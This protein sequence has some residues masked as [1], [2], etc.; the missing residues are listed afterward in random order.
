MILPLLL[1][2]I[3]ILLL[4]VVAASVRH[5]LSAR[6]LRRESQ[7]Q[8]KHASF[9]FSDIR[10]FPPSAPPHPPL[11][12]SLSDVINEEEQR[13]EQQSPS[14]L[15]STATPFQRRDSVGGSQL[16]L[17]S[18]RNSVVHSPVSA[19]SPSLPHPPPSP[20]LWTRPPAF[21]PQYTN[22]LPAAA[23]APSP[24]SR[25]SL[26]PLLSSAATSSSLK[27]SSSSAVSA[28][29]SISRKRGAS[30]HII[31][32]GDAI[33]LSQPDKKS[34]H[35]RAR[36]AEENDVEMADSGTRARAKRKEPRRHREDREEDEDGAVDRG[37]EADG[38]ATK[39][40][41]R[42]NVLASPA[43]AR[44]QT[45][46]ENELRTRKRAGKATDEAT[47]R[48]RTAAVD[49]EDRGQELEVMEEEAE[50]D[51]E[52]T[53]NGHH[54]AD[55][56]VVDVDGS[57]VAE[58]DHTTETGSAAPTRPP[59]T[60]SHLLP[61][62]PASPFLPSASTALLDPKTRR[63]SGRMPFKTRHSLPAPAA[64]GTSWV[65]EGEE[66]TEEEREREEKVN[67]MLKQGLN[68]KA[69]RHLEHDKTTADGNQQLQ[70]QQQEEQKVGAGPPQSING[71]PAATATAASDF[72][73]Q[74]QQSSSSMSL[75]TFSF[76][77]SS[78]ASQPATLSFTAGGTPPAFAF[79][80][81]GGGTSAA[82][83]QFLT[84]SMQPSNSSP[85]TAAPF[86]FNP[87]SQQQQPLNQPPTQFPSAPPSALPTPFPFPNNSA[88]Q[89]S[90]SSGGSSFPAGFSGGAMFG[91]FGGGASG[92]T[93]GSFGSLPGSQ[94]LQA[95]SSGSA[96][97]DSGGS[98]FRAPAR[99]ARGGKGRTGG[100]R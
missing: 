84:S 61:L 39:S 70:Q 24:A 20:F 83:A 12:R 62:A 48:V 77:T 100:R 95:Q 30:P 47:K 73:Q 67:R 15:P 99:G 59:P 55:S 53:G 25:R 60:P 3:A 4:A 28:A 94:P 90:S 79:N 88:S 86:S 64:M 19:A 46:S 31:S 11:R 42:R 71:L 80:G 35:A 56:L 38:T 65:K 98:G 7:S 93:A 37:E 49:D 81:G 6:T 43:S 44:R 13:A 17:Q 54:E 97:A 68:N 36:D 8:R 45:I 63:K 23:A 92:P 76:T 26:P 5:L 32:L 82:S 78:M 50:E 27:P 96:G 22:H 10:S 58:A 29:P 16:Q 69:R 1:G 52:N 18:S 9:V 57:A 72:S 21:S 89:P 91:G 66:V 87:P 2:P 51:A 34:R 40:S 14:P 75:P 33:G 85:S 41:K 74:Q